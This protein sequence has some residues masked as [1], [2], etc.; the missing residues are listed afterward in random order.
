MA[1][2]EKVTTPTL[3][4]VRPSAFPSELP[5]ALLPQADAAARSAPA[6]R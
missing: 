2:S 6:A 1:F 4:F 5:L 3:I